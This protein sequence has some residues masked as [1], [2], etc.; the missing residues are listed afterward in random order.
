M[1]AKQTI[2]RSLMKWD[3]LCSNFVPSDFRVQ[4]QYVERRPGNLHIPPIK[5]CIRYW[6]VGHLNRINEWSFDRPYWSTRSPPAVDVSSCDCR[7]VGFFVHFRLLLAA[8]SPLLT[9]QEKWQP[10]PPKIEPGNFHRHQAS[11]SSSSN[12][13]R[14]PPTIDHL[15]LLDP[16]WFLYDILL[17]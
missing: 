11:V 4:T 12:S 6:A 9:G 16:I 7:F 5:C 3:Q 14:R 1:E 8:K 17:K 13:S 2:N 15:Q 10:I